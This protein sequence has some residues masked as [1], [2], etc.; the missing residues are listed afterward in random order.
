MTPIASFIDSISLISGRLPNG[1]A[2]SSLRDEAGKP[3]SPFGLQSHG[4]AL[5][6]PSKLVEQV[7]AM[8]AVA[9]R[10]N[11]ESEHD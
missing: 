7:I 10:L 3:S 11:E 2:L 8:G 4:A 1:T 6:R 9:K 5:F